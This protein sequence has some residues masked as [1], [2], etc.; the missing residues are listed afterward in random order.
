[1]VGGPSCL[2]E[3]RYRLNMKAPKYPNSENSV[4]SKHAN[5]FFVTRCHAIKSR[6]G[7]LPVTEKFSTSE[8]LLT[9]L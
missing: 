8:I 4:S 6:Q 7:L 9:L 2:A 3:T 1:M 5:I